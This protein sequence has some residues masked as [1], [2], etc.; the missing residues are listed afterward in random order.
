MPSEP[1]PENAE[2]QAAA[3]AAENGDGP[4]DVAEPDAAEPEAGA[5]E[6][7]GGGGS[8]SK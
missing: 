4:E 5:D 3:E 7:G 8:V 2:A 6:D 1:T